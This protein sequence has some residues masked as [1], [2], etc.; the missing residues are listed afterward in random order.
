MNHC[1]GKM[2]IQKN[3]IVA[4]SD[5]ALPITPKTLIFNSPPPPKKAILS[6]VQLGY[7]ATPSS[8]IALKFEKKNPKLG[9]KRLKF[10]RRL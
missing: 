6:L 8:F 10:E 2:V 3:P 5:N 9:K 7:S 4:L 1:E